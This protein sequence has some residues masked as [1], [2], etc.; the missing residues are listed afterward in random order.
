MAIA[1]PKL[2]TRRQTD[3]LQGENASQ[4]LGE[5][6]ALLPGADGGCRPGIVPSHGLMM[7]I[8]KVPMRTLVVAW[9]VVGTAL[10]AVYMGLVFGLPELNKVR[11]HDEH[12]Y[13]LQADTFASGRLSNPAPQHPEFFES[14]YILVS[15]TYQAKYPPAQ[16]VFLAIGQRFLSHPIWGVW[17]SSGIF[18][19][20]LYWMLSGWTNRRWAAIGTINAVVVLGT[21]YWTWGFRGG[22]VAALG[23]ALVLGGTRWTIRRGNPWYG[24]FTGLG[25]VLLANSRPYEGMV[26]CLACSPV[27]AWWLLA[28]SAEER[29]KRVAWCGTFC[30]VIAAGTVASATYNRAVTGEWKTLP[31]DLY[32]HQYNTCGPFRW[33]SIE[34]IPARHLATRLRKFFEDGDILCPGK[35]GGP[36]TGTRSAVRKIRQSLIEVPGQF[37]VDVDFKLLGKAKRWYSPSRILEYTVVMLVVAMLGFFVFTAR[38]WGLLHAALGLHVLVSVAAAAVW[39]DYPHYR[40]PAACIYYF[41]AIDLLRRLS[42]IARG[43]LLVRAIRPRRLALVFSLLMVVLPPAIGAAAGDPD[44]PFAHLIARTSSLLHRNPSGQPVPAAFEEMEGP[45]S[46]TGLLT[47]A[48]VLRTLSLQERP[49]L[50]FV[51]YAPTVSLRT[52]WVYN[53]ADLTSQRVLLA[54]DLG[55]EH[56]RLLIA[57]FPTRDVWRVHVTL[58]GATLNH[59]DGAVSVE[60]GR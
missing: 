41:L 16:A 12:G 60:P 3:L 58:G 35:P 59:Y 18:T 40:A 24:L 56:N 38:S 45:P 7:G 8:N 22:M 52:E 10:P 49:T 26:V 53:L 29:C 44:Y 57:D 47:R 4:L 32:Q 21:S 33:Q 25:A 19:A 30:L 39:W 54:H 55:D 48:A 6:H 28:G 46:S 31:W 17:L 5:N 1:I 34:Q 37:L 11:I 42:L 2:R 14:P 27:L 9:G 15:P 51:S 50:A 43:T 20:A 13:L 36:E 23:G